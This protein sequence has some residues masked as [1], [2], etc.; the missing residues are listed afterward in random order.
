LSPFTDKS[1]KGRR[2]NRKSKRDTVLF[3]QLVLKEKKILWEL[4]FQL[5]T[6]RNQEISR[7][8]RRHLFSC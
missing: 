3:I 4:V 8:M 5:E 7:E 6:T 1:R 2:E